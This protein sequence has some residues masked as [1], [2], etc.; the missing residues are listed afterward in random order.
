MLDTIR[1]QLSPALVIT[2]AVGQPAEAINHHQHNLARRRPGNL[3]KQFK[4]R[5]ITINIFLKTRVYPAAISPRAAL[6]RP[7]T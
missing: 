5:H 2:T 3:L 7:G 1:Q 4:F 6:P